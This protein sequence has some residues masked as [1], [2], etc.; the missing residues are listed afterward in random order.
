M[1]R[2]RGSKRRRAT[3]KKG[4]ASGAASS[5]ANIATERLSDPSH[6]ETVLKGLERLWRNGVLCDLTLRCCS[7]AE[8]PVEVEV[9]SAVVAAV[10]GRHVS[11]H[12]V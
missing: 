3:T 11:R 2:T 6:A 9:H 12:V 10:A 7:E 1:P 8:E 4:S 5:S